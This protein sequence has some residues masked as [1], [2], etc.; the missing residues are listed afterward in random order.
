MPLESGT[1]LFTLSDRGWIG[2]LT[3]G[4]TWPLTAAVAVLAFL[5]RAIGLERAN[6]LHIDE[7]LYAPIGN[8]VAQGNLPTFQGTPF[9]LHPIG[10]FLLDA[11]FIKIF[12]LGDVPVVD[13]VY[14]L[15]WLTAIL[16]ALVVLLAFRL[17]LK[18]V[19][20]P[21][22]LGAA[23]V[24]T[25]DPFV[26]RNDSRVMLETPATMWT[27]GAWL[28]LLG[29]LTNPASEQVRRWREFGVGVVFGLALV[30]K[31]MTVIQILVPLVLAIFW[32]KTLSAAQVGRISAGALVPYTLF[33]IVVA[34]SG[35]MGEWTFQKVGGVR[36]MIGVDQVTGFNSGSVSLVDRLI[37]EISRFGTSYVLLGL[38]LF[39]G[40]GT[41]FAKA[42][43]RRLMG[44]IGVSTGIFGVYA[45][46]VGA[47][48][49]QFGY[50]T[51]VVSVVVSATAIAELRDRRPALHKPLT[52]AAGVFI[53]ATLVMGVSARLTVDDG[54]PQARAWM[55]ANLPP[56]A[57]VATTGP[58]GA[59]ALL[60]HPGWG[61]WPSLTAL[62]DN[63][64]QY[65]LTAGRTL[66]QGY[67]D[68]AP[69]MLVWLQQNAEPRFVAHGPTY[70]DMVV[71]QVDRATL[72]AAIAAGQDVPPVDG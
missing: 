36:R 49:E 16:G 2:Y 51:V 56:D 64:A 34:A 62:R 68:A 44:L 6:D 30:T 11:V 72:D 24:L 7:L 9:F 5:M 55:E 32:R 52:I 27:L 59:Y 40:L 67:G 4:R 50:Y 21:I 43:G 20:L 48:E 54:F 15:R 35:E 18:V 69:Q 66:E 61:N 29:V 39:A 31:D 26:L 41:V 17:L 58:V 3:V 13:F 42:T 8:S 47:L 53:A 1:V 23:A 25:F 60:P 33:V 19:P 28:L 38:C 14:G 10:S 22:A 12:G 37:A 65:V 71:W 45:A 63:N 57:R 70:G 46:A